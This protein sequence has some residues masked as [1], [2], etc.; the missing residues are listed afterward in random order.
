MPEFADIARKQQI[1]DRWY[2][3]QTFKI[4]TNYKFGL[5]KL[6]HKIYKS[7]GLL[8]Q[9]M[10][11]LDTISPHRLPAWYCGLVLYQFQNLENNLNH[12]K[13]IAEIYAKHINPK[14]LFRNLHA[15]NF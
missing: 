9:P 4:R 14:V 5:G 6:T 8:S 13:E 10:G 7:L 1:M 15:A 12:K 11:N 3:D 2:P